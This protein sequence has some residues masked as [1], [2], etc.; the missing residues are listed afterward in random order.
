MPMDEISK[1]IFQGIIFYCVCLLGKLQDILTKPQAIGRRGMGGG[2]GHMPP[3]RFA[4][5]STPLR[6]GQ[7]FCWWLVGGGGRGRH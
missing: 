3:L 7:Y 2:R 4:P 6:T 1:F 5:D